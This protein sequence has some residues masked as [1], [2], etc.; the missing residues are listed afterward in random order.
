[1]RDG[2]R[3]RES[4]RDNVRVKERLFESERHCA[5]GKEIECVFARVKERV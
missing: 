2:E 4:E 1:M 3:Y 5:R